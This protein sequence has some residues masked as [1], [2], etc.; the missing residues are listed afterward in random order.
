MPIT[1]EETFLA[2]EYVTMSLMQCGGQLVPMTA[3]EEGML[4]C[5]RSGVLMTDDYINLAAPCSTAA[6]W[7]P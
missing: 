3:K 1:A 5:I 2:N 7:C 4:K 6:S